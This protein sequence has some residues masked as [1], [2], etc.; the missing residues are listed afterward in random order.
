MTVT[1][2]HGRY[3]CCHQRKWLLNH[4]GQLIERPFHLELKQQKDGYD[5][6]VKVLAQGGH[7]IGQHRER[8]LPAAMRVNYH[9]NRNRSATDCGFFV[10]T[11]DRYLSRVTIFV[12]MIF[13]LAYKYD[14]RM[15][16]ER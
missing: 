14:I 10:F 7:R 4:Q 16:F 5:E 8:N 3:D 12:Q 9:Q 15:N 11:S 1:G 2:F 6:M 13:W